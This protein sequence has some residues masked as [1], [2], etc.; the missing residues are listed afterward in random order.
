MKKNDIRPKKIYKPQVFE[1]EKRDHTDFSKKSF[2]S[3]EGFNTDFQDSLFNSCS[4]FKAKFKYCNFDGCRFCFTDFSKTNLAG[5]TFKNAVFENC[6]F[7]TCVLSSTDFE[8]ASFFN[9][10]A[11]HTEGVLTEAEGLVN[12]DI[13]KVNPELSASMQK[14]LDACRKNPAIIRSKTLFLPQKVKEKKGPLLK[15]SRKKEQRK[16]LENQYSLDR[17]MEYHK[18]NL[19]RLL[20]LYG[21]EKTAA[22]LLKA[23]D[24]ISRD[25]TNLSY[26]IPYM[27]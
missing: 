18:I 24:S 9:T 2:N 14:A 26:F 23:A 7:D 5:S 12:A 3:T 17:P 20:T 10:Y 15:Q 19:A 21:P 8:G 11:I 13:E 4:F 16:R 25:F 22:G 1:N 6:L 27:K